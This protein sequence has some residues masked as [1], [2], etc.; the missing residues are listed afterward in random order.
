MACFGFFD[1]F[2]VCFWF[3]Q[4]SEKKGLGRGDIQD[5][6]RE[7]AWQGFPHDQPFYN[8]MVHTLI[9]VAHRSVVAEQEILNSMYAI[10]TIDRRERETI[11][12]RVLSR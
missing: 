9:D 5:S 6:E 11:I 4:A 12:K 7:N 1:F 10:S 3:G 2:L 8:A